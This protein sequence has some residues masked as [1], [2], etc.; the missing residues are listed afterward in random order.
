MKSKLGQTT[1]FAMM[2]GLVIIILALAL[3]PVISD[4]S[5]RAM[6]KTNETFNIVGMDC[7]NSSISNFNK[8]ACIATDITPF[9]FIGVMILIGGGFIVAKIITS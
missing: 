4:S 3:A 7:T 9:Y 5:N 1:L 8:A 2:I 6:N